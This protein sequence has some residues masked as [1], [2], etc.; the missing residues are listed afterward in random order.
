M[1]VHGPMVG[2]RRLTHLFPSMARCLC[3]FVRERCPAHTFTTILVSSDSQSDLHV[4]THNDKSSVNVVFA[5]TK[6]KGG[7]IFLED[8]TGQAVYSHASGRVRGR[9]L[10]VASHFQ[11]FPACTV[12]H[13]VL[14]WSGHRCVLIAFSV[15]DSK[16]LG[17][18]FT[19]FLLD[20]GF[21]LPYPPNAV[22]EPPAARSVLYELFAGSASLSR[23]C[24][25]SGFSVIAVDH[26]P[27]C[28]LAPVVRFDLS[29][30]LGQQLLWQ[31]FEA[32]P[33]LAAASILLVS[34]TFP[35]RPS[36]V[37]SLTRQIVSLSWFIGFCAGLSNTMFS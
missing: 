6:F 12:R 35:T 23:A 22:Q 20:L 3:R 21:R 30:D 31:Q 37:S 15:R 10:D 25:D 16:S 7:Q 2:V 34:P 18:D 1:W 32:V 17:A 24:I 5:L 9:L 36:S 19:N 4:D 8:A 33:P 29:S 11:Q 28:P 26:Q 27:R 13:A 14:P